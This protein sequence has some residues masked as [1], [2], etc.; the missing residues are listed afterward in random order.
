[1]GA[2]AEA[3]LRVS[4]MQG[5]APPGA[6]LPRTGR[7]S[8][9]PV[10]QRFDLARTVMSHGWCQLA[11]TA[12][13]EPRRVLHRTLALPD[14]GPLTVSVR[15][16]AGRLDASWG[17]VKGTCDDRVAVKAQLRRML[18]L[19]DDLT[20]LYDHCATVPTLA[21]VPESGL[22]RMLRSPDVFEDLAKTLATT[23]CSWAL[24]RLMSR[25]LVD[26]LGAEGPAGERAFPTPAAVAKAGEAHFVGVV[27]AGYRARAFVELAVAYP[28]LGTERW[29][30]PAYD[31]ADVLRDIRA[32]RGFGLYAAEGMLGLLGRPRGLAID[33]WVR[34]KLPG[35]LGRDAMTDAEITAHFAPLG[36]W[37]G[38]GL[39]LELTRDWFDL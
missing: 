24:T 39:W 9:G 20:E 29:W 32:L 8:L 33:S 30:D 21:W 17:R 1:M 28:S 15:E 25:R 23:N 26:S 12:F 10:P 31:D 6:D 27:R 14:A 38:A 16:R 4:G 11:P 5:E 19:D 3:A 35:L 34:A 2:D 22:G 13:D 7:M 36:R 37:A 18:A